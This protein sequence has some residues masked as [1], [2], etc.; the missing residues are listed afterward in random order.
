[1]NA[2]PAPPLRAGRLFR[3]WFVTVTA[4]E[5]LGFVAPATVGALTR[6]APAA[7]GVG[8]VLAAGAV[9]GMMLGLAQAT[10]LRRALP[11]L[12]ARRS[13]SASRPPCGSR[14]SR[15]PSP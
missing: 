9:E 6:D 2:T 5:F 14:D 7:V 10:V 3:R 11:R 8:A 12:P 15:S 13:S 4:G 1:M